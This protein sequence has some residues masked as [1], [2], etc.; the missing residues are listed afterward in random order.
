MSKS[1]NRTTSEPVLVAMSILA[2]LQFLFAGGAGVSLVADSPL[3]AG[4]F[5]V[6][7]LGTAAAQTGVQFYVRGKVTPVV[8][9]P[10]GDA[11]DAGAVGPV[12]PAVLDEASAQ[13]LVNASGRAERLSNR[14]PA[15]H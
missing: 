8:D 10:T 15:V 1:E 4:I 13:V 11:P 6:G 9:S 3:V 5:A 2:G 14:G 7:M 12:T